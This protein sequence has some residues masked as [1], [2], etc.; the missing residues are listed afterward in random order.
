MSSLPQGVHD[1]GFELVYERKWEQEEQQE[2]QQQTKPY[3]KRESKQRL[4]HE[5]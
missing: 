2:R 4:V 5:A 3:G 1:D